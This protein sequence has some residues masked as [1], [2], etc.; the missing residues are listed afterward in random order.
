[1]DSEEPK[2]TEGSITS[3]KPDISLDNRTPKSFKPTKLIGFPQ[4]SIEIVF[5]GDND[6]PSGIIQIRKR[7]N[8]TLFTKIVPK[9]KKNPDKMTLAS[10]GKFPMATQVY[11]YTNNDM[12][13]YVQK[14][15]DYIKLDMEEFYILLQQIVKNV[16]DSR[17][18]SDMF[19]AASLAL[20]LKKYKRPFVKVGLDHIKD[21]NLEVEIQQMIEAQSQKRKEL[22][23]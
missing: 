14:G 8:E 18:M 1:M 17:E 16:S 4:R 20:Q 21:F 10:V 2:S 9:T 15:A 5:K 12:Y 3:E 11:T 13:M 22:G 6:R 7:K 19:I 23:K